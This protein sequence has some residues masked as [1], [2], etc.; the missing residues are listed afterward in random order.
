MVARPNARKMLIE[1]TAIGIEADTVNPARNPTYTVTAPN[2]SPN[3]PP[4]KTARK[5]N[6]V[7]LCVDGTY[8]WNSPVFAAEFRARS[9]TVSS[10]NLFF[11]SNWFESVCPDYPPRRLLRKAHLASGLP[12]EAGGEGCASVGRVRNDIRRE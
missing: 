2:S 6:S 10:P 7:G 11:S 1:S 3:T 12:R 8:G 4:N 9:L 5:E